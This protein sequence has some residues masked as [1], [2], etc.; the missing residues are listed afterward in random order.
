MAQSSSRRWSSR[1]PG[2]AR[3]PRGDRARLDAGRDVAL[4][5]SSRLGAFSAAPSRA[6]VGPLRGSVLRRVNDGGCRCRV[7]R[8]REWRERCVGALCTSRPL[9][10]RCVGMSTTVALRPRGRRGRAA[11]HHG[12]HQR[13]QRRRQLGAHSATRRVAARA[14]GVAIANVPA[15]TLEV[16][17]ACWRRRARWSPA[18]LAA[19]SCGRWRAARWQWSLSRVSARCTIAGHPAF[20]AGWQNGPRAH[21][22]W[23]RTVRCLGGERVVPDGG[24]G[25]GG[26]AARV[27]ARASARMTR[28]AARRAAVT[29]AGRHDSGD[30]GGVRAVPSAPGLLVRR[31]A[32]TGDAGVMA[33]PA[34]RVATVAQ[35]TMGIGDRVGAVPGR[36]RRGERLAIA[37][38]GLSARIMARR[39]PCRMGLGFAGVWMG[40]AIGW[41]ARVPARGAGAR[42]GGPGR[43][44][45]GSSSTE[46]SQAAGVLSLNIVHACPLRS[47]PRATGL[48]PLGGGSRHEPRATNNEPR[49]HAARP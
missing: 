16:G 33:V 49:S 10:R 8:P 25:R 39:C 12:R 40:S 3:P 4:G 46:D 15:L 20:G 7:S 24:S 2:D 5:R 45:C 28:S 35:G 37:T 43:G 36:G 38:A 21:R 22:R 42:A 23:R 11:R 17:L 26:G 44:S 30:G 1:R 34:M 41:C 29:P 47:G 13:G 32:T 14:T 19:A 48:H 18:L 27:A 31:S 9:R 6:N